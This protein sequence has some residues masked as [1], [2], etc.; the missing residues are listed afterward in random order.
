MATVRERGASERAGD[1]VGEQH[2][3][4]EDEQRGE[5]AQRGVGGEQDA[6]RTRSAQQPRVERAH[7]PS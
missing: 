2:R 7:G 4:G 6:Y 1:D 5:H 3:L